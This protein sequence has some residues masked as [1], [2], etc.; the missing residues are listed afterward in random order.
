MSFKGLCGVQSWLGPRSCVTKA[1]LVEALRSESLLNAASVFSYLAW[2][3][4]FLN[5]DCLF[6]TRDQQNIVFVFIIFRQSV[7]WVSV[8][9]LEPESDKTAHIQQ[10]IGLISMLLTEHLTTN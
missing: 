4:E 8:C 5:R 6:G 1:L 3:L 10:P 9:W 2:T 7:W